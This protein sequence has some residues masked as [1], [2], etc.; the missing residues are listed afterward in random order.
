M[1][2]KQSTLNT[3]F[4]RFMKLKAEGK[5]EACGQYVRS[6]YGYQNHHGVVHRRY[7]VTRWEEDN[8]AALCARCHKEFHDFPNSLNRDFFIKKIGTDRMEQLEL[9]AHTQPR[10]SEKSR[11]EIKVYLKERIRIL[12]VNDG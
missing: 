6:V 11:Q 12:K 4:S 1:P 9:M 3:L 8:C 2:V 5:C 10:L 7:S